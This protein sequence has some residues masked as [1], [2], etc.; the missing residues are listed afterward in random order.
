MYITRF[1]TKRAR[2]FALVTLAALAPCPLAA[3]TVLVPVVARVHGQN[4]A[5]WST[6]VRVTNRTDAPKQFSVVDWI[7]TPGWKATTYVVAPHSMTSLG[8]A[9]VFGAFVG[10]P[11]PAGLAICE[12][13]AGLLFQSAVL[14]GIWAPGGVLDFCPSYDGGGGPDC[15]GL[16][17][18]GPIIDGL[19]FANPGQDINIPWLHT[20][21]NRRT[22]LVLINPDVAAAHVEV[23]VQSQDGLTTM[24]D[25]FV[26]APRSYNQINDVFA[27]EPWSA[28]RVANQRIPVYGG[29]AA[30][31]A[32]ISSDTRLLAM[33][34]VISNDNNSLTVSLA[35]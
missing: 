17:G 7:G 19:V 3:N 10:A 14:A 12:A 28:V 16:A 31:S 2:A 34:Y 4:D 18:A 30:A 9:D 29:G 5:L 32:T 23:S 1:V 11:G 15:G 27:Q 24:T 6:E 20:A 22:N 21:P 13:E 33:A 35:R 8:G 26:L 25:T